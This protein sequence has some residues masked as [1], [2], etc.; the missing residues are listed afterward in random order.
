[1]GLTPTVAEWKNGK[2]FEV[3]SADGQKVTIDSTEIKGDAVVIACAADP[4]ANARVSY[5]L[6]GEG[7]MSKPYPGFPR[8]GLLHDSDPFKGAQTGKVQPN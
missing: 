3:T 2:G 6:F 8:W 7:R 4:G 5:A 1:M